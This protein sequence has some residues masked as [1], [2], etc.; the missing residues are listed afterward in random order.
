MHV[1]Q[2]G[3]GH[4]AR[5]GW[6]GGDDGPD[7]APDAFA[8]GDLGAAAFSTTYESAAITV[9]GVDAPADLTVSGGDYAINGGGWSAT[10]TTVAAGDS[11]KVRGVAAAAASTGVDVVLTIGGVTDTFTITT[12][13]NSEASMLIGRFSAD[14]G[15]ARRGLVDTLIG[16]LKAA[17]LWAKIDVLQV[18]AAH[19]SQAAGLNWKSAS[20]TA[21]PQ[22]SPTFTADRG[23]AG[24]GSAAYVDTGFANNAAGANWQGSSSLAT[25]AVGVNVGGT[26]GASNYVFGLT[27]GAA[28]VRFN[29][30]NGTG[31]SGR[32]FSGSE[33]NFTNAAGRIGRYLVT[34]DAGGQA[35]YRNGVLMAA[36]GVGALSV[37]SANLAALRTNTTFSDSRM[38]FVMIGGG[39]AIWTATEAADFDAAMDTYLAAVGAN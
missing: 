38:S 31:A 15:V 22:A 3:P 5:I 12:V 32:F 13:A 27:G 18:Y 36:P 19:D 14:P 21:T 24:D 26:V 4:Q 7:A 35:G 23:Y 2:R 29:P 39:P 8:L 9:A 34:R 28:S 20:F 16:A 11:V 30:Y 6:S 10:P 17:G 33:Q 25:Y 1:G 37:A